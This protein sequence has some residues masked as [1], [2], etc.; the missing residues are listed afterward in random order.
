MGKESFETLNNLQGVFKRL[1]DDGR[2]LDAYFDEFINPQHAA[3]Y[4]AA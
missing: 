2:P 1:S 3:F 4:K